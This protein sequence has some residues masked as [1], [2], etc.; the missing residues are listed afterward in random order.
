MHFWLPLAFA[1]LPEGS[2]RNEAYFFTL[3]AILA[4]LVGV[5]MYLRQRRNKEPDE[6]VTPA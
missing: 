6:P 4:A 1:I 5:A 3:V 2:V